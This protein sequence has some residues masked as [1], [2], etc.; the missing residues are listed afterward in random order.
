MGE[1]TINRELQR[2]R[3]LLRANVCHVQHNA[4]GSPL[5][6]ASCCAPPGAAVAKPSTASEAKQDAASRERW[7]KKVPRSA[8][9]AC[10]ELRLIAS[11]AT[12]QTFRL[13]CVSKQLN[14]IT[15]GVEIPR[16]W[17]NPRQRYVVVAVLL[18]EP[19]LWLHRLRSAGLCAYELQPGPGVQV[20]LKFPDVYKHGTLVGEVIAD[21]FE[22]R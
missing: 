22:C 3:D 4:L 16:V 10:N 2:L 13:A 19:R 6:T 18:Q 21:G 8:L 17:L 15:E 7:A 11:M 14:L 1:D 9:L 20:S 12:G 5:R